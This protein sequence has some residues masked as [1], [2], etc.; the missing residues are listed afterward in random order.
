MQRHAYH[1]STLLIVVFRTLAEAWLTAIQPSQIEQM[2]C[3][4]EAQCLDNHFRSID[5]SVADPFPSQAL[6]IKRLFPCRS[7]VLESALFSDR[8]LEKGSGQHSARDR[9]VDSQLDSC[10]EGEWLLLMASVSGVTTSIS[11]VRKVGRG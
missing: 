6:Q 1:G 2:W 5:F 3:I 7:L 4:R 10:A 9:A 8:Y 11:E